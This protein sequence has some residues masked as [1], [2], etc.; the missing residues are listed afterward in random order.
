M[1]RKKLIKSRHLAPL[2]DIHIPKFLRLIDE[3]KGFALLNQ[4]KD[5]FIDNELSNFLNSQPDYLH[6]N[7]AADQRA[8]VTQNLHR[9][10]HPKNMTVFIADT[11]MKL[12]CITYRGKRYG[13]LI[14]KDYIDLKGLISD[15][16]N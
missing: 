4:E 8:M 5:C 2:I 3:E 11:W 1:D 14:P 6:M 13:G 10:E 16:K 15:A 7:L 12:L 9:F